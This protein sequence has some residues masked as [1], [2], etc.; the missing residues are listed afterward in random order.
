MSFTC[1]PLWTQKMCF[2][3]YDLAPGVF[4]VRN[5]LDKDTF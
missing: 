3:M 2:D 1:Q 4:S 5:E